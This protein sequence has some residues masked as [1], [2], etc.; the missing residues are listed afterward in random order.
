MIENLINFPCRS[1]LYF[2]VWFFVFLYLWKWKCNKWLETRSALHVDAFLLLPLTWKEKAETNSRDIF[3]T[4]KKKR[5]CCPKYWF[6]R[7]VIVFCF[8]LGCTTIWCLQCCC[9]GCS[10]GH[11][12]DDQTEL[13]PIIQILTLMIN[14]PIYQSNPISELWINCGP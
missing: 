6:L 11:L 13:W 4:R 2:C 10:F 8:S 5:M 1:F 3:T 14:L 7:N 9:V 12:S